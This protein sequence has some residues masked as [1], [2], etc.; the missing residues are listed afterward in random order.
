VLYGPAAAG[1]TSALN[2]LYRSLRPDVRGQLVSVKTGNDRTLFFDFYPPP[3][4]RL[5]GVSIHIQI[6][7]ASGGIQNDA[8]RR[9]LLAACDGILFIADSRRGREQD[10][11][12]ALEQMRTCLFDLN[13]SLEQVPIVLAWNKRDL[14]DALSVGELEA[15][16]NINQAPSFATV[17][18]VGQGIFDAFRALSSRALDGVLRRRPDVLSGGARL[19]DNQSSDVV[20]SRRILAMQDTQ[21]ALALLQGRYTAEAAGSDAQHS[22]VEAADSATPLP[23]AAPL[24]TMSPGFSVS[25]GG[26]A[27]DRAAPPVN[28][29]ASPA[30]LPAE[31]PSHGAMPAPAPPVRSQSSGQGDA[32]PARRIT[33]S[34]QRVVIEPAEASRSR[35]GGSLPAISGQGSG[36]IPSPQLGRDKEHSPAATSGRFD[37]SPGLL[38]RDVWMSHRLP[39]GSLRMQLQDVER[40]V[41][42]GQWS[43]GVR[44]AASI[45]YAL[46]AAEATRE[47]D[48][49]P[50]WRGLVLGLPVERYLRFRQAVQDAEAGKCSLE[51]GLFAL[52]FLLDAA[53]RKEAWLTRGA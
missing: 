27:A 37:S 50:A 12:H 6:Y 44:R 53:L 25:P 45:F 46:T 28:Q 43:A 52:F 48:E 11:I 19:P 31:S 23:T 8:T 21:R 9:S 41:W 1:K 42:A 24:S 7:T 40:Q 14:V 5:L 32:G 35:S 18:Q 2:Y 26:A 4:A 17:A 51:D 22:P 36:G 49:G 29:A 33:S 47:P 39:P 15:G 3:P 16:L 34:G 30:Q 38:S 10:N 13:L 20:T